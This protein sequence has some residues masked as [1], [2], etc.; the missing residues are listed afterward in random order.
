M[1]VT[2]S[3]DQIWTNASGAL[4]WL[5]FELMQMAPSGAIWELIQAVPSGEI[6]DASDERFTQV[7]KSIPWVRCASGNV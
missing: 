3:G 2:L 1:Q 7:M 6:L 5:N 4:L